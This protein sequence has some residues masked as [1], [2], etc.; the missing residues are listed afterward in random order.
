MAHID[1]YSEFDY[2]KK[3]VTVDDTMAYSSSN[4]P[5]PNSTEFLNSFPIFLVAKGDIFAN[6]SNYSSSLILPIDMRFNSGH[7]IS[8]SMYTLLCILSAGGMLSLIQISLVKL[9]SPYV[10]AKYKNKLK[11][12]PCKLK[13]M[14]N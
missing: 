6:N 2:L 13:C 3:S 8:I 14:K 9:T 7:I 5:A 4:F 1:A 12:W 10:I 11:F